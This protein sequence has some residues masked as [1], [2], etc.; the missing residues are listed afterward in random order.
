MSNKCFLVWLTGFYILQV[1]K[2]LKFIVLSSA[3]PRNA[4]RRGKE[5]IWYRVIDL[6][7]VCGNLYIFGFLC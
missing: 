7:S 2:Y 4:K 5:V 3:K 6:I 1:K